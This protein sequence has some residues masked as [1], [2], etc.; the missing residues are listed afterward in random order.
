MPSDLN[1]LMR[2]DKSQLKLASEVLARA[3]ADD[4][5]LVRFFSEPGKRQ[6]LL[7]AM[8]RM[9]LIQAI[10]HG[11]AYATS[12]AMEGVAI[13]LPSGAP[14]ISPWEA[15]W[16]GG[17][18]VIFKGGLD[19]MRRMKQ[20][21]DSVKGLRRHLA[22]IPHWYLA[23]L[24]VA[25]GSQGKGYASR[26]LRPVLAR[27]DAEGLPAYLETTTEGYVALYRHFGF[28]VVQEVVLPGSGTRMWAMLR[29][30]E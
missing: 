7:G 22:P 4:R 20:D 15:I 5:Q 1:D 13:W 12:L 26:L 28:E 27:L 8:F 9:V 14:S 19:F 23:V 18:A 16:G 6:E 25:P 17:L 30:N 24:G 21:E 29:Q 2:L 11:E 3:F 10:R